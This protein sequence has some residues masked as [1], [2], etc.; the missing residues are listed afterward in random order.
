MQRTVSVSDMEVVAQQLAPLLPGGQVVELR[1]IEVDG[2]TNRTDSGYF[3]NLD[4]LARYAVSYSGRAPAVYMTVNPVHP[5]LLARAANRMKEYARNTTT[6]TD[7]LHRCWFM[8]DCDPVRP[9]GIASTDIEHEAA[10]TRARQVADWLSGRGWPL[11]F[12]ADS[13]NGAHLLYR[14]EQLPNSPEMTTLFSRALQGVAMTFDDDA[15]TIDVTVFNAARIWKVYGTLTCKG[16]DLP[17]RPHRQARILSMPDAVTP[18]T[19]PLLEALAALVPDEEE[20]RSSRRRTGIDFD[21]TAWIQ[22][23]GLAVRGPI[24]WGK[25]GNRWIFD[26]CPWNAQHTNKSA[27]LVQF[28]SGAIAAGC[29]HNGCAG[30]TWSDLRELYEGPRPQTRATTQPEQR[31][32][33]INRQDFDPLAYRPED[34]GVLDAWA[35]LYSAQW[36]FAPGWDAWLQWKA[37]HWQRDE[38]LRINSLV[39]TLLDEMNV[40]AKAALGD[41]LNDLGAMAKDDEGKGELEAEASRYKAMLTATKRSDGRIVSIE[42]MAR[43]RVAVH[44]REFNVLNVLNL[45][46]GTLDLDTF[47]LHP[48]RQSDN[49]TYVLP[50]AY[51]PAATAPR[52]QKFLREVLVRP[53]LDDDGNP[54]GALETDEEVIRLYQELW[55]YSLTTRTH[56]QTLIFQVGEGGNGKSVAIKLLN[57]LLGDQL[58]TT[59][60]FGKLGAQGNYDIARIPGRRVLLSTESRKGSYIPE[61]ILKKI[62]DGEPLTANQKYE[63]PFEFI[64]VGKIWWS[65]NHLPRITDTTMSIWRRFKIIPFRRSFSEK[66]GTADIDLVDKLLAEL[67]GIL[68]WALLGWERLLNTGHF[69][70]ASAVENEVSSYRAASNPVRLWLEERCKL[71]NQAGKPYPP[72]TKATDVYDDYLTWCEANG[73]D[74][75]VVVNSREFAHEMQRLGYPSKR[76]GTGMLYPLVLELPMYRSK[77][78]AAN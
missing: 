71:R 74:R 22:E 46:N 55:G 37:T 16:D 11:P 64:P 30:H 58:A 60:D 45:Q 32:P 53:V 72:T 67:P 39:E 42:K 43:H 17:E 5:A 25:G 2:R 12:F 69:T 3:D 34:G 31:T 29:H 19:A 70:Q 38:T 68:N 1:V 4:D 50:Y 23:H 33:Q 63:T 77:H 54:T 7:I 61:D 48:H 24:A 13:G 51:D 65:M 28:P 6:D 15:V 66:D 10:L 40:A 14:T 56:H 26:T 44:S 49:L 57:A 35:D 52:W 27:Y 9:S 73:F 8:V 18:V 36:R 59:I 76:T 47:A 78:E 20:T 75:D 41:V 21:L 62:S